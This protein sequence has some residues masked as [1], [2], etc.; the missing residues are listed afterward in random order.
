MEILRYPHESLKRPTE[1]VEEI[2]SEVLD[3]IAEMREFLSKTRHGAGLA[4][5]QVG[6]NRSMFITQDKVFI[7]PEIVEYNGRQTSK[8]GCLS[9]PGIY[10]TIERPDRCTVRASLPDGSEIEREFEGFTS[11]VIQHEYDHLEGVLLVD[12]MTPADKLGNRAALEELVEDYRERRKK[13]AR[14]P[15]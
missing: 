9:F 3:D 5:N 6:I 11:R 4:A 15:S 2:T 7:N 1:P 14:K 10:A 13:L 12:R 8:E